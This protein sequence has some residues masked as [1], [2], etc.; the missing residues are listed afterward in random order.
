M[1]TTL[2]NRT[3][4]IGTKVLPVVGDEVYLSPYERCAEVSSI[5]GVMPQ[6]CVS[7]LPLTWFRYVG[8]KEVRFASVPFRVCSTSIESE[9]SVFISRGGESRMV[10]LD[11]LLLDKVGPRGHKVGDVVKYRGMSCKILAFAGEDE[12][13]LDEYMGWICGFE[14]A[15][16]KAVEEEKEGEADKKKEEDEKAEKEKKADSAEKEEKKADSTEKEEESSG[17]EEEESSDSESNEEES[18]DEEEKKAD[19]WLNSFLDHAY[20]SEW[21]KIVLKAARG[22]GNTTRASIFGTNK[23]NQI[24]P[25]S[26]FVGFLRSFME[27]TTHYEDES[28]PV[29][30]SLVVTGE[31]QAESKFDVLG[32]K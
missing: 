31:W 2:L 29:H 5:F 32:R 25:R 11:F 7:W 22:S 6:G 19:Q 9:K 28:V 30:L 10:P 18:A 14:L 3:S 12:V 20:K 23:G 26:L 8:S 16:K 21:K 24:T 4:S 1:K 27:M 17:E 15:E 13:L